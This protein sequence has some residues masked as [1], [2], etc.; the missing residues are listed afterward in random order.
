MSFARAGLAALVTQQSEKLFPAA[1]VET[2]NRFG[3]RAVAGLEPSD[4][5]VEAEPEL[6]FGVFRH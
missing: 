3:Q 6:F 4:Y 5:I 2:G 1:G